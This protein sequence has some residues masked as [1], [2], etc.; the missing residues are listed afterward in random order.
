MTWDFPDDL[1][2]AAWGLIANAHNGDWDLAP[3]EWKEAAARWRDAYHSTIM[4]ANSEAVKEELG[5]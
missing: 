3:T 5:L 2:E 1:L 4:Q